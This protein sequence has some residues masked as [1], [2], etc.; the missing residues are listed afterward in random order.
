MGV[1]T[2][3][4]WGP[5]GQQSGTGPKRLRKRG[6]LMIH[7]LRGWL[8]Y[9]CLA[10]TILWLTFALLVTKP[11][12]GLRDRYE[13]ICRPW[14]RFALKLLKITCGVDVKNIGMENMPAD[15]PVVV[16]CKHQSAWDPFW[17]GTFLSRPPCFLYKRSLNW[18]PFLG[19]ALWSMDMMAI[20]R[21]NGRSAFETFM[22][23]GPKFLERGWWITLFPE[24]TRVPPGQRVRYKTGGARF[25][26]TEGVPILPIAHNAGR[27]WPKNSIA[28][29]PGTI[30]V[31]VG[32]LI[33]TAGRDPHEV[34]REVEAWIEDELSRIDDAARVSH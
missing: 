6:I 29:I 16:L 22:K 9:I 17:L 5:A 30:T 7:T 1:L 34:T 27:F 12:M 8:F 11:F 3:Q 32:P 19:W 21:S 25:A 23:K 13:C 20:D 24:G 15:R 4:L 14:A 28:K 10:I 33:E 2:V 18:I 26:C 31:S